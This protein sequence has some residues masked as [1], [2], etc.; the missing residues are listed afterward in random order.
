MLASLSGMCVCVWMGVSLLF[1]FVVVVGGGGVSVSSTSQHCLILDLMFA[2]KVCNFY[3]SYMTLLF[4]YFFWWGEQNTH[5]ALAF[6]VP[7]GWHQEKESVTVTVLQVLLHNS[8]YYFFVLKF[9]T[10]DPSFHALP[11]CSYMIQQ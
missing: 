2:P 5:I 11:N 10:H 8:D 6:G 3:Y 7:G 1:S 9:I 4:I